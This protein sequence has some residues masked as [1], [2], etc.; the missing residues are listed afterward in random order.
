MVKWLLVGLKCEIAK[1][2]GFKGQI[3]N[4]YWLEHFVPEKCRWFLEKRR[5]E[6]EKPIQAHRFE[7]QQKKVVF[8]S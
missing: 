6:E 2:G 3:W 4:L 1:L 7:N 8:G 5:E